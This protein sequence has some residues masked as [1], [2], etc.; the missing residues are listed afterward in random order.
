MEKGFVMTLKYEGFVR[1]A[2]S[3]ANGDDPRWLANASFFQSRDED[4]EINEKTHAAIIVSVSIFSQHNMIDDSFVKKA[5]EAKTISQEKEL[6][7]DILK[8]LESPEA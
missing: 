2:L 7:D 4:K 1:K 5:I 3:I 8:L 6:I